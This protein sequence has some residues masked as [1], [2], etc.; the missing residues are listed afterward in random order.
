MTVGGGQAASNCRTSAA[1][2]AWWA[3][4]AEHPI[5]R[6]SHQEP[7]S[8][9]LPGKRL[10]PLAAVWV[11]PPGPPPCASLINVHV[12]V[13]LHPS[14]ARPARRPRPPTRTGE[15]G[16][17]SDTAG[18]HASSRDHQ[19]CGGECSGALRPRRSWRAGGRPESLMHGSR[20]GSVTRAP[21]RSPRGSPSSSSGSTGRPPHRSGFTLYLCPS[22]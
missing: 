1:S 9:Q 14:A 18:R 13:N 8:V 5:H 19:A 21:A 16:R 20:S 7:L 6:R 17:P 3:V 15:P 11:A 4:A 22:T 12:L 2:C 10:L